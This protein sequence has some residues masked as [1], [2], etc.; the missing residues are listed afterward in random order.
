MKGG[1]KI[2]RE[3]TGTNITTHTAG[4][5]AFVH[6]NNVSYLMPRCIEQTPG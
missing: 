5:G 2:F 4:S 3:E 6:F 1:K